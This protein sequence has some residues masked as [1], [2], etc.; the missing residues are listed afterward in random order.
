MLRF[1]ADGLRNDEEAE[2]SFEI[3]DR[4]SLGANASY[5]DGKIKNGDHPLH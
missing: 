1:D 3:T 4:W 2:A 5:A